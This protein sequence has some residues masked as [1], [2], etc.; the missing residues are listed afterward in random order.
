MSK[1]ITLSAFYYGT[2]VTRENRA[3]DFSEDGGSSEIQASLNIGD[4]TLEDFALEIKR[5]MRVAGSLSYEVTVNRNTRVITISA[6]SPFLLL[7]DTGTR[8][9]EAIWALAG[10]S[11]GTDYT[12]ASTYSGASGAGFE[13]RCQYPVDGYVAAED[14]PTRENATFTVTPTGIGQMISFADSARVEMDIRLITN[15]TTIRNTPFYANASGVSAFR[16]FM[17]YLIDKNKVEFIPDVSDR[18]NYVKVF[19][20]ATQEDKDGYSYTLKNM[21]TPNIYRS[22]DLTFRKVIE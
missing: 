13:Y 6:P 16:T 1:I 5:A 3:L 8:S 18:S 7:T 2:K 11:T 9:T 21:G 4:Y 22:G 15:L 17:N 19:L 14:N 12:G 20:E 10:F